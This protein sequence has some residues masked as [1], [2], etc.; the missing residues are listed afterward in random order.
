MCGEY[1][2]SVFLINAFTGYHMLSKCGCRSASM[3]LDIGATALI[4]EANGA[5]K[6]SHINNY[7][8]EMIMNTEM[9]YACAMAA[10]VNGQRHESGVFI[11]DLVPTSAGK[12]FAAKKLGEHRYFMQDSAGGLVQTMVTEKELLSPETGKMMEKYYKSKEGI[13]TET[14]VRAFKLVEDLTSS[15]LAGW[16]H[17]MC[18]SGGGGPQMLKQG[19]RANYDIEKLKERAKKV[20]GIDQH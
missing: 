1:D 16:Y 17:A 20:A 11:P 9:V 4:A 13:S 3:E 5:G 8:N 19:I 18:I 6:A 2:F 7:I 10:A 15:P 14:R 12:A